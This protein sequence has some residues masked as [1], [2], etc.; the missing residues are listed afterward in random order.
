MET[1]EDRGFSGAP[2]SLSPKAVPTAKG[3]AGDGPE[4]T[5]WPLAQ[6][7]PGP[8]R[9][10][11]MELEKA[12]M[13]FELTRLRCL[14]QENERQRLHEAAMERLQQRA[15]PRLVGARGARGPSRRAGASVLAALP[16]ASPLHPARPGAGRSLPWSLTLRAGPERG[17]AWSATCPRLSFSGTVS[18]IPCGCISTALHAPASLLRAAMLGLDPGSPCSPARG[19]DKTIASLT[20]AARTLLG[21]SALLSAET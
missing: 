3:Q 8:A 2:K 17:S 11:E 6:G 9:S 7:A 10:A 5:E 18:S 19:F 16:R 4:L 14:H 15:P 13:E 1:C 12:R 21:H 20:R